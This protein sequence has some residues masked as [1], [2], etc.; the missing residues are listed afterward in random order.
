MLYNQMLS[1]FRRLLRSG[2]SVRV[3]TAHRQ[4]RGFPVERRG[5][6]VG[7]GSTLRRV[8]IIDSRA[9]PRHKRVV[10]PT[11]MSIL[12]GR[13]TRFTPKGSARNRSG[14]PSGAALRSRLTG[15]QK[16]SQLKG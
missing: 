10:N 16:N 6:V 9:I 1:R 13:D 11:E 7:A 8:S 12:T 4:G 3:T 14:S 5:I 2:A 15:S